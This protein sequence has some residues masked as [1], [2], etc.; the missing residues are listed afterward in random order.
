MISTSIE[1]TTTAPSSSVPVAPSSTP[2]SA[3]TAPTTTVLPTTVPITTTAV[4]ET[5][6]PASVH[7][8]TVT[9]QPTTTAPLATTTAG[10]TAPDTTKPDPSPTTAAGPVTCVACASGYTFVYSSYLEVPQLGTEPVR[11]TGCGADGSLGTT[12]PDGIWNGFITIG[13]SS[14]KMDVQ[15]VYYGESAQPFVTQCEQTQTTADC[16]KRGADFWMVNNNSR[17]RSVPL[18]PGFRRRYANPNC[19]DPGPGKGAKPQTAGQSSLDTWVVIE[20]GRATFALTSCI[21]N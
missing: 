7:V 8:T 19:V 21:R 17:T 13:S 11:G 16:L 14:M 1:P 3:T 6:P 20:N 18:D 5:I 2:P 9:P 4:A 10:T 15:C 12:I